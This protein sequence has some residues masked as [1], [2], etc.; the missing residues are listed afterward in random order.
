MSSFNPSSRISATE[1]LARL[2]TLRSK[3]PAEKLSKMQKIEFGNYFLIPR[4]LWR[5]LL[6]VVKTGQLVLACR[7]VWSS[8]SNW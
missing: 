7:I 3:I 4:S 1:A 2:R 6:E 5:T 8:F